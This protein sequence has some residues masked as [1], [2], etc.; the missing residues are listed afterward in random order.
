MTGYGKNYTKIVN[1]YDLES[2]GNQNVVELFYDNVGDF[3]YAGTHTFFLENK[4]AYLNS[5]NEWFYDNDTGYLYVRLTDDSVPN[6]INIRAKVQTYS[7]EVLCPN[8]TISNIN[9]FGSTLKI[10]NTENVKIK[11]CDFLYPSCYAHMLNQINYGDNINPVNQEIFNNYTK[12]INCNNCIIENCVFKYVDGL[13]IGIIG[14]NNYLINNHFSYI[15]KSLTNL[16]DNAATIH[17]EGSNNLIQKNTIFKVGIS[18]TINP[19]NNA[20]IEYNNIYETGFLQTHGAT[21]SLT[22]DQQ[23]N[24]KVRYNWVHDTEKYGIFFDG[25]ENYDF[26]R[27]L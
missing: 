20:I 9:F 5:E 24:V 19:G 8:I 4:I 3:D 12:L 15:D 11:N 16:P 10:T 27:P 17:I 23:I 26:Q 25:N 22:D 21:I 13:A 18:S 2:F 7:L 6:M 14:N 1:D